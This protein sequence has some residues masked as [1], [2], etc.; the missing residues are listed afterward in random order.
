MILINPDTHEDMRRGN[1]FVEAGD[2]TG[3]MTGAWMELQVVIAIL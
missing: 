3:S 2:V 1:V